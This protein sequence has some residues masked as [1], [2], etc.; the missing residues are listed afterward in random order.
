MVN[1][2]AVE[3]PS[4]DLLIKF[5]DD[6]TLSVPVKS[7]LPDSSLKEVVN[8]V[9]WSKDNGMVLNLGKT[10]EMER[11][12]KKTTSESSTIN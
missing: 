10:W 11:Q 3:N 4:K 7:N 1:Y 8:I 12:N 5:P 6:M 2:I 9:N